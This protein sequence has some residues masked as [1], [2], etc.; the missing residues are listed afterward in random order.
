M[1]LLLPWQLVRVDGQSMTPTLRP[2][3]RL[4]VRHGATVVEGSVVLAR[5][6]KRPELLVVKRAERAAGSGWLVAS[7]NRAA[8]TDSR[9]LGIADVM[10]RAVLHLPGPV[11]LPPD[12]GGTTRP[13]PASSAGYRLHAASLARLLVKLSAGV[14]SRLPRRLE[15]HPPWDL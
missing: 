9:E 8:G 11:H 10:A 15:V 5:F 14:R 1:E 4:L 2:G 7:D 6:R 12:G 3:D 13:R